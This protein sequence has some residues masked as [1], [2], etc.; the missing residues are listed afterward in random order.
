MP[1]DPLLIDLPEHL[2]GPRVRLRPYRAGDGAALHEA[3]NEDVAHLEP[4]MVW[5]RKHTTLEESE[6]VV[7][8]LRAAWEA[9]TDMTMGIYDRETGRFLGGT[10][11]HRID[12]DV[13]SFEIGYW[14]RKSAEGKG[15]VTEAVQ[16]LTDFA[17]GELEANRIFLRVSTE[18]AKSLAIPERLGFEREGTLRKSIRDSERR[19]HDLVMFAKVRD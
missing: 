4:Y 16:L 19:L 9:R 1:L 8:R 11:L 10:G 7:R 18:N 17:F 12:W 13:R 15:Y 6:L 2:D 14:I 5:A 3:V